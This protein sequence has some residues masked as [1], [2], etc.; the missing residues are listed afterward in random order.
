MPP[1]HRLGRPATRHPGPAVALLCLC[2]ATGAAAQ[3]PEPG[4]P[5][6]GIRAARTARPP[7]I[8]GQLTDEDWALALPATSFTQR[9]PDEGKAPTER[10]EIRFLFDDDALYIGARLYDTEPIQISR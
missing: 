7:V 2:V 5:D 10:T 1:P 9:D 4:S 8:D 6:R 3:T